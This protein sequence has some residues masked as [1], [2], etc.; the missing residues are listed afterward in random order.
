[1]QSIAL[2]DLAIL[3]KDRLEDAKVL[4]S[5]SRFWGSIYI[6]GYAV[7]FGLKKRICKTL[8]RDDYPDIK[9]LKTHKLDEPISVIFS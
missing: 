5:G 4:Y 7:E 8:D 9:D 2:Q 3:A 6:C 1:M